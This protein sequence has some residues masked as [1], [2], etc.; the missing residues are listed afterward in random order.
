MHFLVHKY[1][2][3][4]VQ[5]VIFI[6]QLFVLNQMLLLVQYIWV[7]NFVPDN[8]LLQRQCMA[9]YILHVNGTSFLCKNGNDEPIE[10][11]YQIVGDKHVVFFN[12][13]GSC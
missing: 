13:V 2:K 9:T 12:G 7:D 11:W 5:F 10:G 8:T 6:V 1:N 3:E 4:N